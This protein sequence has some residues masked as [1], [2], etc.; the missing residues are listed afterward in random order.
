MVVEAAHD[1]RRQEACTSRASRWRQLL[2]WEYSG[3]DRK[4]E[5]SS[6]CHRFEGRVVMPSHSPGCQIAPRASAELPSGI[7]NIPK[8][9]LDLA[10]RKAGHFEPARFEDQVRRRTKRVAEEKQ[11]G[12][13]IEGAARTRA[14]QSRQSHGRI[15]LFCGDRTCGRRTAQASTAGG[16][17]SRAEE[18]GTF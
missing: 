10:S 4:L 17:S 14:V 5:R 18:G 1:A 16:R 7:K 15:T 3:D 8:D 13:K 2:C 12:Q 11:S 6:S 9:M